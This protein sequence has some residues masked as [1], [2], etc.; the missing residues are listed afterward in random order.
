MRYG[1]GYSKYI[2]SKQGKLCVLVVYCRLKQRS[3]KATVS[4]SIRDGTG[5]LFV[6]LSQGN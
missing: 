1:E 3:N 2:V 4:G 5:K 6:Y